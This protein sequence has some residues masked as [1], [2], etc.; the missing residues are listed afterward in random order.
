[1][2]QQ[3]FD[4]FNKEYFGNQ[5]EEKKGGLMA[6]LFGGK[7]GKNLMKSSIVFNTQEMMNEMYHQ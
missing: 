4:D 6:G 5:K 2:K 7:G 1:M 3:R